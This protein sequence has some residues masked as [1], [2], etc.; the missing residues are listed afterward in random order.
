MSA[1]ATFVVTTATFA[2]TF[3]AVAAAAATTLS[4]DDVDECLDLL[5]GSIVHAQ[6]LTLKYEVHACVG[7]V[8]VDSHCLILYLYYEAIHALAFCIDEGDDVTCVD[9]L[10]VKLAVYAEDVLVYIKYE[11]VAAVT[12]A[13]LLGKGEVEGVALL[14]VIELSFES[15]ESEAQACSKLEGLLGGSLLYEF[16]NAFKLGI[17]VV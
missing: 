6:Y 14:Q 4:G 2:T 17:H 15:L 1:A 13:L 11:V 12:V 8:E 16:F 5:L 3:T 7:V 9:L 10:I